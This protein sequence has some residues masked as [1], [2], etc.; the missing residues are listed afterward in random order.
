MRK[1][2]EFASHPTPFAV[3]QSFGLYRAV[4][5]HV[6]DG[7]TVMVMLDLGCFVYSFIDVRI[8]GVDA[9]EVVGADRALGLTGKEFAIGYFE[10]KPLL[11]RTQLNKSGVETR[12]FERYVADVF[13][14]PTPNGDGVLYAPLLIAAGLGVPA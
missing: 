5:K 4:G 9:Y 11:V 7:D 3:A 12:S 2:A 10:N 8:M 1:P 14:E 6:Y 13:C